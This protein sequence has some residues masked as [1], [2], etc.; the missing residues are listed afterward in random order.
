MSKFN[1]KDIKSRAAQGGDAVPEAEPQA[2]LTIKV[3]KRLRA[4]WGAQA[5]LSG[6][7]LTQAIKDA[8]EER[9]GLPED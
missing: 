5:K 2:N 3:P 4:Y 9:F 6:T 7:S 8:L 1:L